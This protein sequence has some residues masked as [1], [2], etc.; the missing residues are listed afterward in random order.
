MQ[1]SAPRFALAVKQLEAGQ[2]D[3]VQSVL[4]PAGQSRSTRAVL[5]L[6]TI[7]ALLFVGMQSR[8]AHRIP[9]RNTQELFTSGSDPV[10]FPP[11]EER[12]ISGPCD[13][14]ACVAALIPAPP[15]LLGGELPSVPAYFGERRSTGNPLRAPPASL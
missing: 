12:M 2:S 5:L 3:T 15:A 6:L 13:T 7:G 9:T 14:P 8:V 4:T 11:P 10:K 1:P